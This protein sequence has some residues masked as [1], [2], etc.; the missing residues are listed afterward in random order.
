[1]TKPTDPTTAVATIRRAAA[2]MRDVAHGVT[3]VG[4]DWGIE[5]PVGDMEW[6]IHDE[7]GTLIAETPDY[8]GLELADHIASWAPPVALL[9][10]DLLETLAADIDEVLADH[11][12]QWFGHVPPE[13]TAGYNLAA[14]FLATRPDGE[15]T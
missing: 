4:H 5:A 9:V 8:G 14:R 1:M 15:G 2:A 12:G 3:T 13:W 10:A 11:G 6:T 7:R